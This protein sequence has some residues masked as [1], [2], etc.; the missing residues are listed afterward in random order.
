MRTGSSQIECD[1][2]YYSYSEWVRTKKTVQFD[3]DYPL[4]FKTYPKENNGLKARYLMAYNRHNKSGRVRLRMMFTTDDA[5]KLSSRNYGIFVER[6]KIEDIPFIR[7]MNDR[8]FSQIDST[9]DYNW[10]HKKGLTG[11]MLWFNI[12]HKYYYCFQPEGQPLSEQG[13]H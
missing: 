12:D 9:L 2:E 5:F 11:H 13:T 8:L 7:D 4:V 10:D 1:I 3:I 6:S